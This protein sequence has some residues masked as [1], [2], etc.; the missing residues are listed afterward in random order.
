MWALQLPQTSDYHP[1]APA[2]L[3]TGHI[4]Q[5]GARTLAGA[6]ELHWAGVEPAFRLGPLGAWC[7]VQ[8]REMQRE[9][10]FPAS[11]FPLLPLPPSPHFQGHVLV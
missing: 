8:G 3:S 1:R 2:A 5:A 7:P 11:E 6:R 10:G 9:Y 4:A